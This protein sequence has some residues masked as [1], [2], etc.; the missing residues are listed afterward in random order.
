MACAM[1]DMSCLREWRGPNLM[2]ASTD[3]RS[4]MRYIREEVEKP[5]LQSVDLHI[6]GF[7]PDH[8]WRQVVAFHTNNNS[9][10]SDDGYLGAVRA[11]IH[12]RSSVFHTPFIQIM[13]CV[14]TA[15]PEI[16][17]RVKAEGKRNSKED[18]ILA[19]V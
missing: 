19:T 16:V 9:N 18:G 8:F 6:T 11:E 10:P 12:H 7:C 5:W 15:H 4:V 17:A 13:F 3:T 2:N 1:S 14:H